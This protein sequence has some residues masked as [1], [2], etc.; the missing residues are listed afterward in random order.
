MRMHA[1]ACVARCER[2]S[3]GIGMSAQVHVRAGVRAL[4]RARGAELA[5]VT[6]HTR[7][8]V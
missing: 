8:W 4:G 6:V 3:V 1:R 5:C 2:A 7:A